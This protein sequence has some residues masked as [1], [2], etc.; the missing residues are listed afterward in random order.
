MKLIGNHSGFFV[1]TSKGDL[2][3]NSNAKWLFYGCMDRRNYC[4]HLLTMFNGWLAYRQCATS[5]YVKIVR[6]NCT[7]DSPW[8]VGQL[9]SSARYHRHL[10]QRDWLAPR[11]PSAS[12]R[13]NKLQRLI[14]SDWILVNYIMKNKL[15]QFQQNLGIMWEGKPGKAWQFHSLLRLQIIR[16]EH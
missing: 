7:D 2:F 9:A 4:H 8:C 14:E 12:P 10:R 3:R 13:K 5:N 16:H 6:I 15:G 11:P 1:W